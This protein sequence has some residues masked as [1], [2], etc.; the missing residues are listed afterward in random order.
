[1]RLTN[2]GV[3]ADC[4]LVIKMLLMQASG[5]VFLGELEAISHWLE[6]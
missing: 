6:E 5:R 1:M 4:E 3:V 2:R